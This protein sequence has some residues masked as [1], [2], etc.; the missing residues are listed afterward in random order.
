MLMLFF[1]AAEVTDAD[2]ART[3]DTERYSRY[4]GNLLERGVYVAP[5]QFEAGFVSL[6]HSE[7]DIDATV[8]AANEALSAL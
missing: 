4:F 5:S 2:G 7:A 8:R 3:A 6:A 1:T